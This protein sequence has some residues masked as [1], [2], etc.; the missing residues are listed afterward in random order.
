MAGLT[1]KRIVV[2]ASGR[3]SNFAAI[4]DAITNGQIPEAQIA[5]L[6]S[7]KPQAPVLELAQSRGIPVIVLESKAFR[8]EN[9][10]DRISYEKDLLNCLRALKPDLIC[11]AGYLLLLGKEII[12]TFPGKIINIHP[13]LLPLF[14]GLHSQ[15]QAIVSGAKETGCTVH[16]VTESLDEGPIILQNRI[17]ILENETEESL[18]SRLLPV[19]HAT[20]IEALKRLCSN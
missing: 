11:L 7:N 10:F 18:I 12:Q 2:L 9:R 5:A 13:S 19:E 4:A 15:K 14:K 17:T 20:Y 1:P 16:F 3:G 8:K 6:I